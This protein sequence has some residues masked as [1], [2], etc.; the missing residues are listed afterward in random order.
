MEFDGFTKSGATRLASMILTYWTNQGFNGVKVW[1][2]PLQVYNAEYGMI[3]QVRSN[4]CELVNRNT[5]LQRDDAHSF[6]EVAI[7][8]KE[9]TSWH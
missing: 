2:E 4:V 8:F 5:V 1:I 7:R 9:R 3:W 6:R